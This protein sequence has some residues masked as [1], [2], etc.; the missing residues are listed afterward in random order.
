MHGMNKEFGFT[1]KTWNLLFLRTC[2]LIETTNEI[3]VN[4]R[5][6]EQIKQQL[7]IKALEGLTYINS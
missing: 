4:D 1:S 3:A 7:R 5:E 2:I 6:Y